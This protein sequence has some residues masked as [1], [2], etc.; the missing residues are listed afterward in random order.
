MDIQSIGNAESAAYYVCAYFCKSEPE[1]MKQALS[2]LI[3]NIPENTP[4][5]NRL[6]K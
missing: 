3:T 4:Q 1:D 5:R 6:I 2:P